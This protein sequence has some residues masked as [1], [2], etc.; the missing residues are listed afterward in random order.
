MNF[1]RIVQC[2]PKRQNGS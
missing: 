1:Y 2:R